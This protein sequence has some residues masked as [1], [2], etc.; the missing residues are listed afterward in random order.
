MRTAAVDLMYR[1]QAH[2]EGPD[3]GTFGFWPYQRTC[4][5]PRDVF[6]SHLVDALVSGPEFLGVRSPA[7]ITFFPDDLA[8]QSDADVTSNVYAVLLDHAR[9]D[10]GPEVTERFERFFADWRDLGQ[11]PRR[12]NPDWLEPHG[13]AFLTW[14][15]YHDTPGMWTPND[16]D[17]VVNANVLY[18]L[19]RS[20]RLDTPGADDAIQLIKG[21][22]EDGVHLV[23]PDSLALYYPY[24]HILH[25]CV[26][27]AFAEGEVGNLAPAVA[28]LQEDLLLSVRME[29]GGH[30][31]WDRGDPELNTALAVAAL[32]YAGVSGDV[33]EGAVDYLISEQDDSGGWR[34]G[35]FFRGR[36]DDG[37]TATWSSP[38]F[39][40]AMVLE[41]LLLHQLAEG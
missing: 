38:A 37:V 25:Y 22:L 24:N 29:G 18:C 2:P 17:L 6:L 8:I 11:V 15:A 7:N 31:Y 30:Y 12:N 36:T 4:R 39:A 3:A 23:D 33:V 26:T 19:G 1:F 21:A 32:L 13:G 14:L 41:A 34:A 27:R 28:V 9:L 5:L 40:T 35:A 16:V 10:G 20:G